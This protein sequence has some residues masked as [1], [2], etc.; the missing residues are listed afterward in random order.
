VPE[1]LEAPRKYLGEEASIAIGIGEEAVYVAIGP[2]NLEAV[3]K[4]ID[5]SAAEPNKSIAPFELALSVTPF[6]ELAAN[7]AKDEGQR[8]IM[9]AVAD[10]LKKEAQ[11][12]DHIR[13]VGG[14]VPHGLR[15]RLEAE[16][17]VL[18]GIGK[19]TSEA[20]R[21]MMEAAQQPQQQ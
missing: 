16:E 17:G 7:E 4:A 14:V 21:Q 5:A 6:I 10:S 12:R 9:A 18:R 8:K 20:Q 13:I 15:Y 3:N 11:G 2:D 1:H 19:A